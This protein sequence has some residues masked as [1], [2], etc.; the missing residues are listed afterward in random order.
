MHERLD[1]THKIGGRGEKGNS[2]V[3][4]VQIV[5]LMSASTL[6]VSGWFLACLENFKMFII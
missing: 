1:T 3:S 6:V 4:A 5:N 2:E